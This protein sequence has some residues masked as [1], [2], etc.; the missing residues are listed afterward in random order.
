MNTVL[1]N[2][3]HSINTRALIFGA[4]TALAI[5]AAATV[6]ATGDE[7]GVASK[8]G[9]ASVEVVRLEPVAV[10]I[11]PERFDAIRAESQSPSMARRSNKAALH[12]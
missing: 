6:A 12:G 10:T 4:V 11:T 9:A 8:K 3:I 2:V 5:A 1:N 7:P